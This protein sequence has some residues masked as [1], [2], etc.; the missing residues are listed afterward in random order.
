MK[1]ITAYKEKYSEGCVSV[2][3]HD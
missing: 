3:S 2:H 1:N